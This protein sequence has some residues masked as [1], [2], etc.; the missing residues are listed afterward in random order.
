MGACGECYCS[1]TQSGQLTRKHTL[2]PVLSS[3][4]FFSSSFLLHDD[5]S[6]SSVL[7][8]AAPIFY[9]FLDWS[10]PS[11]SLYPHRQIVFLLLP[12]LL[13]VVCF[14]LPFFELRRSFT[15]T[16]LPHTSFA[17]MKKRLL[18]RTRV[19]PYGTTRNSTSLSLSLSL[20]DNNEKKT[21]KPTTRIHSSPS[22]LLT[23]CTPCL[24]QIRLLSFFSQGGLTVRGLLMPS[25]V[26]LL[27]HLPTEPLD[28]HASFLL[29]T[30]WCTTCR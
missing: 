26:A 11:V 14:P 20:C 16:S 9:M 3:L 7:E 28:G 17:P 29:R 1:F 19:A 22:L 2:T 23:L 5:S 8:P 15:L 27:E 25:K 18:L 24:P 4:F 10:A 30:L 21:N 13:F 12:S 6:A